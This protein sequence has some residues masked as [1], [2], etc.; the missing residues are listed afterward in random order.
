MENKEL[1]ARADSNLRNYVGDGLLELHSF[2][3]NV[4][5]PYTVKITNAHITESRRIAVIIGFSKTKAEL[6]AL[7][8]GEVDG[9]VTDAI[10]DITKSGSP[11]HLEAAVEYFKANPSNIGQINMSV[12]NPLQLENAIEIYRGLNPFGNPAMDTIVPANEKDPTEPNDKLAQMKNV[13]L[14]WDNQTAM[15]VTVNPAT[16]M[17][18]TLYV[19]AIL[20]TAQALNNAVIQRNG[21]RESGL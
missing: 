2:G 5:R 13:N 15:V 16:T 8:G 19:D 21:V 18:L 14:Q 20:N 7:I 1:S 4:R 6:V 12:D 17:T 9:I 10:A 11:K 3:G